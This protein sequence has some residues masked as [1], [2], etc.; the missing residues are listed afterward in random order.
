MQTLAQN[1]GSLVRTPSH[2]RDITEMHKIGTIRHLRQRR[3]DS[4]GWRTA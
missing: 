1:L 2:E 4:R 3:N